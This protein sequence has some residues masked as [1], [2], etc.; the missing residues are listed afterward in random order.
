MQIYRSADVV[1]DQVLYGWYGGFALEMMAMGK[2]VMCY[3][4]EEDFG[5]VPQAMIA[6]LP[7]ININPGRLVQ[8]IGAALEAR[9]RWPELSRAS[10]RFALKWHNP[11]IIAAAMVAAYRDGKSRFDLLSFVRE[12]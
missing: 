1:I 10:R 11:A 9:A 12:P 5:F 8:D 6:D 3:L 2:P 7:I 4:R